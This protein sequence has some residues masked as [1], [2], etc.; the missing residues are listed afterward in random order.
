MAHHTT[1]VSS[2]MSRQLRRCVIDFLRP[3]AERLS[4]KVDIR[5]VQ[6]AVDLIQVFLIHRHRAMGLLLSELGGFLLD[7]AHA[8]A[9]TKRISTLIHASGWS[10]ADI[11][12]L[13]WQQ[14]C[15]RVTTLQTDGETPLAIWDESV[16][17]KPESQAAPEWCPVRSSKGRRLRRRRPGFAPP[18]SGPPII[19][20]G[21]HWLGLIV[22]GWAGPPTLAW[23]SWWT[24]R[25][26]QATTLRTV[27]K[28]V[29]EQCATQWGRTVRHVWDRGFGGSPWITAA[30]DAGVRFVVRWKKGNHLLD[31]WGD[32]RPAWQVARG[33]RT[34]DRRQLRDTRTKE[35]VTVGVVWMPVNLP[36]HAQPLWLV[37]ARLGG[38]REP[39]YLLTDEVIRTAAEAW[40]VVLAYARRWQIEEVFRY[41]KSE[42]AFESIRVQCPTAREK[43]LLLVTLAYAFLLH[44][45]HS[46][47]Q[48]LCQRLLRQWNHRTGRRYQQVHLPLYRLRAAIS[49]LWL[50]DP[51][52][53]THLAV[54]NSG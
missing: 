12:A 34:V 43:L 7:P 30:L 38:G 33:K 51:P 49:R 6:T 52:P 11:N 35:R 10:G 54:L 21:M 31:P 37:V 5:L 20:P 4:Q 25:G 39:W 16:L 36:T 18:P 53:G 45:M 26:P 15:D 29:L 1:S 9:G 23:M 40:D 27:E 2:S 50:H 3:F 19:V 14:A 42:L 24:T 32:E 8:P 48:D 17:E 28:E 13:L 41:S 44:L 22:T 46:S 47:F